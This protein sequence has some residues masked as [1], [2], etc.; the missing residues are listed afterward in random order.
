M[1]IVTRL[2][3]L[4]LFQLLAC[5][6]HNNK[7]TDVRFANQPIVTRVA[8]REPVTPMPAI[9]RYMMVFY[10]FEGSFYQ[11]VM[12]G[13]DLPRPQRARG[14][15]ALD[16][17][18]D[19]T[20][21][22]NRNT[23]RKLTPEEVRVGPA[24]GGSPEDF[25]PW[26]IVSTKTG[27]ITPGLIIKDSR[28]VEY[29]LKF[30]LK[31]FPETETA[32]GVIANRLLWAAGLNVP[33]DYVV[34]FN[35]S[36]LHLMRDSVYKLATTH[37]PMRQADVD[38]ILDLTEMSPNGDLRGMA[39]RL[40]DGKILGGHPGEGVREDDP[41]DVIPHELR[42]DLRGLYAVFAWIDQP[43][44]KE[45]N[46]IDVFMP[47]RY[48]KHYHIDF[49]SAFGTMAATK[50]D[51]RRGFQYAFDAPATVSS[52]VGLGIQQR[53]W[54]DRARPTLRGV[55]VYEAHNFDPGKWHPF[56]PSYLPM[57]VSDR[58]DNYWGSKLVMS[59]TPDQIR[60]AVKAGRLT[61]PIAEE[62]L[63]Q[64]IIARQRITGLYWFSRVNPL[65][66]FR[67]RQ[68]GQRVEVCFDDLVHTNH[69]VESAAH[70]RYH[71]VTANRADQE[72]SR[73]FSIR[74]QSNGHNCT[75]P[76]T[77]AR[78]GDGYTIL[79]LT[80]RGRGE[81]LS[82]HV[83]LARNPSTGQYRLIGVYRR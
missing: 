72:I 66:Q 67:V 36:E 3:P 64:Q 25:R 82:T 58:I 43:D 57:L 54:E 53:S 37:R 8:D 78:G 21:F 17:V 1:K 63:V 61:D 73:P 77:T 75:G 38:A 79:K 55:G 35:K 39:S 71:M 51:Q 29:L 11:R 62:Y 7:A 26:T 6:S 2:V 22:T 68:D 13:L 76:L 59:F 52:F 41:N 20:W 81:P 27:G 4:V 34:N 69:L 42:R 24:T 44:L 19:S 18:P 32:A 14:V 47:G 10:Q 49:G 28:G 74:A 46:S 83:H 56:T 16:E 70:T 5:G 60:A 30:D 40:I 31:G 50:R 23:K 15:N 80:T 33:Q 12:R 65:D 48:V 45:A 9:R